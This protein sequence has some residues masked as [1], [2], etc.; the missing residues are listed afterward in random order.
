MAVLATVSDV[1]ELMQET[2]D[3][4]YVDSILT[5]VDLVL[6]KIFENYSGDLSNSLLTEFQK[7]YAA[8]LIASTTKRMGAEENVGD[9]A[10]KYMGSFSTGLDSTP[11]GQML[12]LLDV[13]GM[14]AK[15]GKTAA[16]IYAIK[17]FS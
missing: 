2:L 16:S 13:T 11:Y 8:H 6:T 12:K 15:S 9:A 17:N 5:T 4:S 7:Y 3:D 1:E 10:I 14:L